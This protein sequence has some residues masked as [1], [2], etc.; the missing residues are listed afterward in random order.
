MIIWG[1][2]GKGHDASITVWSENVLLHESYTRA[3]EH[4]ATELYGLLKYGEPDLVVWYE[5]PYTK[6]FRQLYAGQSRPFAR[7]KIGSYLKKYGIN[8]KWTYVQHHEAHAAHFYDQDTFDEA[9]VFVI[10]S[11]GEWDCTS[12]W[13]AK[14]G[15]LKKLGSQRYPDSLGLFYSSMVKEAGMTP[16]KDEATFESLASIGMINDALL[17]QMKKE[18]MIDNPWRPVFTKNMHKGLGGLYETYNQIEIASTT[19]HLFCDIVIN[20]IDYW[21]EKLGCKNVILSGGCAFNR[22]VRKRVK[23]KYNI[24]VPNNPGDGGSAKSAVLAYLRKKTRLNVAPN[25]IGAN[26]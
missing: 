6:S 26:T 15:K 1:M 19:Q 9:V 8:C 5:N 17:A 13:H 4:D 10:D 16:Q 20:M 22:G 2:S 14:D 23:E 25:Q 7:N 21:T 3:A 24:W 11:I 18:L 12:V